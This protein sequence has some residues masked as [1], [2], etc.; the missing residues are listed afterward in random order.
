MFMEFS[1][2][3][4]RFALTTSALCQAVAAC[5]GRGLM[6]AG[7]IV[8]V[9]TRVRR[10]EVAFLAL[11][12]R[13]RLGRYRGG[14]KRLVPACANPAM[15]APAT[16]GAPCVPLE[17]PGRG[18]LP[19]GFGWLM[20]VM[21]YEAACFAGQLRTLL[22]EPDMQALLEDV[23]RARRILGPVCRMLGVEI[24]GVRAP[25]PRPAM[26]G[27]KAVRVRRVAPA[28]DIGRVPLPR[29]VLAAARR[30]GYGRRVSDASG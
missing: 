2:P 20:R 17:M 5:L 28:L 12:E 9:W 6:Q 24:P 29:G 1:P 14:W 15:G 25:A 4:T 10:A 16:P 8:L 19:V 21:P 26:A 22:A 30:Q 11:L 23:A 27:P 3:A 18:T 7:M 13:V